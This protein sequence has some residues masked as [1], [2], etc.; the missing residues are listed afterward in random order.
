ML[1]KTIRRSHAR[2]KLLGAGLAATVLL[3]GTLGAHASYLGTS[4][5]IYASHVGNGCA[6]VFITPEYTSPAGGA[7]Y[8]IDIS[9]SGNLTQQAVSA[10][11]GI[12]VSVS[13]AENLAFVT[14]ATPTKIGLDYDP[15]Q[16]ATCLIDAEGDGQIQTFRATNF[17]YPPGLNQE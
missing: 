8:S 11:I 4:G 15:S 2:R 5:Y 12:L 9:S 7:W 10:Q 3:S 6:A 16:T 17:N 1:T 14:G 13:N